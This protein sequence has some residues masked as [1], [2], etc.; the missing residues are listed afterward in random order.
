MSVQSY[1]YTNA[2]LLLQQKAL[3][4]ATDTLK[5]ALLQGTYPGAANLDTDTA[6]ANLTTPTNYEVSGTGYTAG[7][8]AVSG[9]SLSAVAAASW[10]AWSAST[11][12]LVGQVVRNVTTPFHAFVCVVAGT[13]GATEPTWNTTTGLNTTDGG[14][15]WLCIGTEPTKFTITAPSWTN[16][17]ITASFGVLYSVTAS[18]ALICLDDFGG[19]FSST[20][21]PFTVTPDANSGLLVAA[22]I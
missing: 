9:A 7:G 5:Y 2:I 21:G 14:A 22:R 8:L 12:Y 10:T 11:A 16:A 17:T 3:N 18:N 20:N 19:S 1:W 4:L 15:T 13:S 6:Y